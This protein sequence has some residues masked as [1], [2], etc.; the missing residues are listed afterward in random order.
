MKKVLYLAFCAVL[1]LGVGCA[2]TDYDL[3]T[4]N[5]QV[6]NGQGSGVVNTNGKAYVKQS[7][8][9]ATTYP[10]GSDNFTWFVDQAANGDRTLTTYNN[11]STG[12]DP[13]FADDLYCAPDRQGCAITTADDPQV[14]DVDPFDYRLNA[15]CS[16]A[17]SLSVLLGTTRYYGECGRAVPSLNDRLSLLYQGDATSKWGLAGLRWNMTPANSTVVLDNLAGN[18]TLV[19]MT[20]AASLTIVGNGMRNG[21]VD[22]TNPA[23]KAM[24]DYAANWAQNFSSQR[25]EMVFTYNGIEFKKGFGLVNDPAKAIRN[26]MNAKY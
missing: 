12:S 8:Q 14:G 4:D 1:A 26:F 15:N 3:I 6:S 23:L 11:F 17:R 9:V 13:V 20:G 16:G 19:P 21:V 22:M 2:L 24:G 25:N 18:R 5:D 7:S 10:D